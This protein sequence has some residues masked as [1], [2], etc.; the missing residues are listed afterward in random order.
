MMFWVGFIVGAIV[1]APIGLLVSS[2]CVAA[3]S[4]HADNC[5]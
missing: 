3:K 4:K 2:L 1:G 5:K